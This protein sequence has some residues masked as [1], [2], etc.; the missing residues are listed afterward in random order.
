M[1]KKLHLTEVRSCFVSRSFDF[2]SL[3]AKERKKIFECKKMICYKLIVKTDCRKQS[4][5]SDFSLEHAT[6]SRKVILTVKQLQ[7]RGVQSNTNLKSEKNAKWIWIAA[8][9]LLWSRS[10]LRVSVK[11]CVL[12]GNMQI[13]DLPVVPGFTE[14]WIR[15]M[16]VSWR[17]SCRSKSF[18]TWFFGRWSIVALNT[19]IVAI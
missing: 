2:G 3:H 11:L 8:A 6:K 9:S 12:G 13:S 18:S 16:I 17:K 15:F 10:Q 7:L 1:G 4:I 19:N 14:K 5:K